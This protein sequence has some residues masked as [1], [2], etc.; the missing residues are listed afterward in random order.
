VGG[1][2]AA[3]HDPVS[4]LQISVPLQSASVVQS[5][6]CSAVQLAAHFDDSGVVRVARVAQQTPVVQ[7]FVPEQAKSSP[8][9]SAVVAHTS[10]PFVTQHTCVAESQALPPHAI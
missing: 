2:G 1:T 6:A 9:Q 8:L 5:C 7:L 3:T 10:R 4:L